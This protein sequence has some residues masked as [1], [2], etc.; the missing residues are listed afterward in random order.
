V[1]GISEKLALKFTT[2]EQQQ[3]KYDW[4][5][6]YLGITMVGKCRG[7]I[8]GNKFTIFNIN[9]FPE[10]QRNGYGTAVITILRGKYSIIVAN[11][12]RSTARNFWK[13]LGF[14]DDGKGNFIYESNS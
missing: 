2:R 12:V 3:S 11:R 9:I 8:D 10:F 6:I 13:K 7:L 1:I 14:I 4:A 5:H